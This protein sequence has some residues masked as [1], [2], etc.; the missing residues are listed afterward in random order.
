MCAQPVDRHWFISRDGKR[1]GPYTFEALAAAA[2]K[3]VIDG[4]TVVWRLGWVQ[5]HPAS[6]VPGLIPEQALEPE[7][8]EIE[9][10]E[11]APRDLDAHEVP[12]L[13]DDPLPRGTAG[14]AVGAAATPSL[15]RAVPGR[16]AHAAAR[17]QGRVRSPGKTDARC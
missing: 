16:V 8:P 4:E 12:P 14:D 6:R 3:G 5:W 13:A 10:V 7:Q 11:D 1:Y 2:A 9:E 15:R 17:R